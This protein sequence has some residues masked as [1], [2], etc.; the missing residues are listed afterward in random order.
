MAVLPALVGQ[1]YLVE[2]KRLANGVLDNEDSLSE[3]DFTLG[4]NV[5]TTLENHWP[6][7]GI[8][9]PKSNAEWVLILIRR[10]L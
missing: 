5:G 7:E 1:H 2:E 9:K 10:V 6:T 8:W 3:D 4:D